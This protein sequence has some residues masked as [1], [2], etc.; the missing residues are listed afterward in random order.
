MLWKK[1]VGT[2][3]GGGGLKGM[4]TTKIR[5]GKKSK[6][7]FSAFQVYGNFILFSYTLDKKWPLK[8]QFIAVFLGWL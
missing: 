5:C 3:R 8:L 7:E 6:G 1:C 2:R 4:F